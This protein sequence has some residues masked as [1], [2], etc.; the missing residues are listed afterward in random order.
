[1]LDNMTRDD[2]VQVKS[3]QEAQLDAWIAADRKRKK[4]YG[5]DIS[6]L[7]GLIAAQQHDQP[8]D[9]LVQLMARYPIELYASRTAYRLSIEREKDALDRRAGFQ[10]RDEQRIADRFAQ[11]PQ[12]TYL[13]AEKDVME[14]ILQRYLE[15]E[16]DLHIPELDAWIVKNGGVNKVLVKLF[17]SSS[18]EDPTY[19]N[20]LLQYT[21]EEFQSSEMN[22]PWVQLA[23]ILENW[24]DSQQSERD[25]VSGAFERLRPVY[26]A[27]LMEMADGP[28]YPDANGTLRVSIGQI[29]GYDPQEA[30]TYASQ[31][32]V[33]GMVAKAGPS[34]F[35]LPAKVQDAAHRVSDSPWIDP[36]LGTI[37]LN[38]ISS[39]DNTGGNSGSPTLNGRGELVGLAFDRNYEGMAADW[40]F[41][42][43][44]TR[45]IHLDLRFTWWLMSEVEDAEHILGE[46]NLTPKE[47]SKD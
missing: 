39:L 4:T 25:R 46:L 6:E 33:R 28:L 21:A 11:L 40:A 24:I 12:S 22:S 26:M 44:V 37:P 1:M 16:A 15:L 29:S 19:R 31:T 20:Q 45:S 13:L 7:R 8:R 41:D 14:I 10:T 23:V 27:A 18:I 2:L 34:P 38:F 32:T 9:R 47:P 42:H 30:V 36:E 17:E 5:A 35:S 43:R 3:N